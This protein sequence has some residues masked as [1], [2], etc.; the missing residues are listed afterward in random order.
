MDVLMV[1]MGTST[2]RSSARGLHCRTCNSWPQGF[3]IATAAISAT[4][5]RR[6][7]SSVAG[8]A[9]IDVAVLNRAGS[10]CGLQECRTQPQ[11]H[12]CAI[13]VL[14][15]SLRFDQLT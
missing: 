11:H 6:T 8:I 1:S 12:S 13:V 10:S 7:A 14:A 9:G 3:A 2:A 5:P 15:H 4:V